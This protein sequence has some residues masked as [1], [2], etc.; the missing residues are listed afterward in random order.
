M[1]TLSGSFIQTVQLKSIGKLFTV[2]C[3]SIQIA[4]VDYLITS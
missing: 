4:A 1:N 2:S 3:Q